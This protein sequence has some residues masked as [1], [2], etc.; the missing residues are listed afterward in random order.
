MCRDDVAM[1]RSDAGTAR[2]RVEV[3]DDKAE[4][5]QGLMN[6]ETLSMSAGMLFIYPEP[7]RVG[8]WMKNTLIPL[9]MIFLDETGT[10]KKVHH[11]AQPLDE[12]P[13][14]GGS[15]IL[16]V[17]EINGG[18]SRKIGISEGWMMRHPAIDQS[19]AAWT[20]ADSQ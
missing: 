11:E 20:C 4:R 8:F 12:T 7:Q 3:A 16:A 6:R 5:A 17:L 2:F 10:V 9:D 13:I 1:L 14:M 19:K 15:G 18:L